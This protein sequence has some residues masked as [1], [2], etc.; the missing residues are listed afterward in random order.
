TLRSSR[1]LDHDVRTGNGFPQTA[2]FFNAALHI[3]GER[4]RDFKTHI[5]VTLVGRFVNRE[6]NVSGVLD[7]A[8]G[9]TLK[10]VP[11]AQ[12]LGDK[13]IEEAGI[14]VAADNRLF[15]DGGV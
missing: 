2:R 1:D 4:G 11:S 13:L 15:K 14:I 6:Q 5:A 12:S 3:A 9:D 8:H 7:V 10:D